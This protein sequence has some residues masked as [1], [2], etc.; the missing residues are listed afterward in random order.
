MKSAFVAF[1]EG[2]FFCPGPF[3]YLSLPPY[4]GFL[5]W[6]RFVVNQLYGAS[7]GCIGRTKTGIMSI[8]AIFNVLSMSDVKGVIRTLEDVNVPLAGH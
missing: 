3:F 1:D 2:L 5:G 4:R 6:M 7:D 8:Q